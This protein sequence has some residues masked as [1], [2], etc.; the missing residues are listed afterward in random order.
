M[1]DQ[2]LFEPLSQRELEILGLVCEGLTDRET[3]ERFSLA[4]PTVNWYNRQSFNKLGV[5]NR[6][7]AIARARELG[8]LRDKAAD[9]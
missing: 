5:K 8:L 7:E 4:L 2:P 6:R 1:D 3:A 9:E